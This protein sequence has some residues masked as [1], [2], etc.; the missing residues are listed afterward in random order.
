[1]VNGGVSGACSGCHDL[2]LRRKAETLLREMR[3]EIATICTQK[4]DA[5]GEPPLDQQD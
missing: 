4:A 5:N 1:M 3:I 2:G